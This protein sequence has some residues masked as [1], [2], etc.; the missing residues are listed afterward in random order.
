MGRQH[1]NEPIQGESLSENKD[2]DHSHEKLGLLRV[3]PA[4]T[5]SDVHITASFCNAVILNLAI[6]QIMS[7]VLA[8][9]LDSMHW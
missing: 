8:G 6:P 5:A 7:A 9:A 2:Q 4:A 3:G 1:T